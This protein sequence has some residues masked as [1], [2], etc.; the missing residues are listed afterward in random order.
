[1][2]KNTG[3]VCVARRGHGGWE[4]VLWRGAITYGIDGD[5][6]TKEQGIE[7]GKGLSHGVIWVKSIAS[8]SRSFEGQALRHHLPGELRNQQNQ[9][10]KEESETGEGMNPNLVHIL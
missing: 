9:R 5:D 4:G 10:W 7:G 6:L 1:M 3:G 8:R 2:E